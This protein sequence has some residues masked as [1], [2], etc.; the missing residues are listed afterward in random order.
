MVRVGLF[1]AEGLEQAPELDGAIIANPDREVR[2]AEGR[3]QLEACR[4]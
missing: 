4:S 1:P 2:S 3:Q